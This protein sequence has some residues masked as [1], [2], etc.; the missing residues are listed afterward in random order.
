MFVNIG[1][2]TALLSFKVLIKVMNRTIE[3]KEDSREAV[4][5]EAIEEFK[6]A[7]HSTMLKAGYKMMDNTYEVIDCVV[8]EATISAYRTCGATSDARFR[9]SMDAFY[10]AMEASMEASMKSAMEDAMKNTVK[11]TIETLNEAFTSITIGMKAA[12]QGA[13]GDAMKT[14]TANASYDAIIAKIEADQAALEAGGNTD[15]K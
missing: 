4:I 6:D 9:A 12:M 15:S 2:C 3:A 7:I 1:I 14:S 11:T 13:M 10:Y 8:D 5:K